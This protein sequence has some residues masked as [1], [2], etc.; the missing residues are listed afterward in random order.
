MNIFYLDKNIN[1]NARMHVDKHVVKMPV[2]YAQLLSTC[3]ILVGRDAPYRKTHEH[4]PCL[5]WMMKYRENYT[6]VYDLAYA[7]G[8]EY[9]RRYG[10]LHKSTLILRDIP[11]KIF[12]LRRQRLFYKPEPPN[13]SGLPTEF[14]EK[15]KLTTIY[16]YKLCYLTLKFKF[17]SYRTPS[18][19]PDW[20][21]HKPWKLPLVQA[22]SREYP[23]KFNLESLYFDQY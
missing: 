7:V 16:S 4:H 23:E 11:R 18:F 13:V 1:T 17:S 5:K 22:L 14:I 15:Y 2:E 12:E 19:Y 8:L 3:L 10:R 6:Y 20:W 9:Y 21:I